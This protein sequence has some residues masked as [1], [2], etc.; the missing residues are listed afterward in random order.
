MAQ[1]TIRV[2]RHPGHRG[3]TPMRFSRRHCT[4]RERSLPSSTGVSFSSEGLWAPL[5]DQRGAHLRCH[6][7]PHAPPAR[8]LL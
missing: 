1:K 4:S 2:V 7:P 8:S 6:D 3:A 5:H